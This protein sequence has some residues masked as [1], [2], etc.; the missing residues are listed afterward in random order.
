M[1]RDRAV[2]ETRRAVDATGLTRAQFAAKAKVDQGTLGD[3]LNGD[4]WPQAPTRARIEKALGWPAGR[5]GE[6]QD[7]EVPSAAA[8][9]VEHAIQNDTALLPEA[10]AHL[11]AQYRLLLRIATEE[12]PVSSPAA[13]VLED[14]AEA[15]EI[16]TE[17]E[18]RPPVPLRGA[19]KKAAPRPKRGRR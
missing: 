11:L 15:L 17:S 3:F 16:A 5:I 4:R 2:R 8:S 10:R 14:A 6:L 9:S 1:S 12:P 18:A 7:V 19:A 13:Q